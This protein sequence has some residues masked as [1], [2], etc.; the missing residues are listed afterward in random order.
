MRRYVKKAEKELFD[1]GE[2]AELVGAFQKAC[3]SVCQHLT[4]IVDDNVRRLLA[5]RIVEK[6]KS[7]ELNQDRLCQ[8]AMDHLAVT[9]LTLNQP[10]GLCTQAAA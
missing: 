9:L 8:D 4:G 3:H 5:R 2:L 7:G 10:A 1:P 6:A